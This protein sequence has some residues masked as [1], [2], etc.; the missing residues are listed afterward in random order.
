MVEIR[1]YFAQFRD[2]AVLTFEIKEGTMQK[3]MNLGLAQEAGQ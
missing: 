1:S 2:E 3:A